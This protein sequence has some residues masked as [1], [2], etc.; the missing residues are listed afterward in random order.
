MLNAR[1]CIT[2]A[3][4]LANPANSHYQI[5]IAWQGLSASGAP[6]ATC[7]QNAFSSEDLRR[8]VTVVVQVGQLSPTP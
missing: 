5:S 6:V 4:N 3:A 1:G 8:A 2:K 7:G